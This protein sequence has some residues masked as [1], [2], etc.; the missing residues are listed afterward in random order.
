MASDADISNETIDWSK[1]ETD[2]LT[3][4]FIQIKVFKIINLKFYAKEA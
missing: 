3:N 2:L 1:F 4:R